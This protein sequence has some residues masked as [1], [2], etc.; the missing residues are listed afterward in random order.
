MCA[1]WQASLLPK[2][3]QTD[4]CRKKKCTKT[5]KP[6]QKWRSYCQNSAKCAAV[7]REGD[8]NVGPDPFFFNPPLLL[9]S[10]KYETSSISAKSFPTGLPVLPAVS[11]RFTLPQTL[12]QWSDTWTDRILTSSFVSCSS[13]SPTLLLIL[14]TRALVFFSIPP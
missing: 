11:L 10:V 12:H 5:F 4:S 3:A 1:Y 13:A 8:A 6:T 14:A 7:P 9:V 2:T